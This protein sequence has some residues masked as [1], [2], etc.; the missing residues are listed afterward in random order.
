MIQ[1]LCKGWFSLKLNQCQF[2]LRVVF[3]FPLVRNCSRQESGRDVVLLFICFVVV[4]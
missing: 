1:A 3:V 2:K 4:E